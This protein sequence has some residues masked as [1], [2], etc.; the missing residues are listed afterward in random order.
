[1]NTLRQLLAVTLLLPVLAIAQPTPAEAAAPAPA[2]PA[3]AMA[4][5]PEGTPATS[6]APAEAAT[7]NFGAGLSFAGVGTAYLAYQGGSSQTAWYPSAFAPT[8]SLERRLALRTWLAFGF[9]AAVGRQSYEPTSAGSSGSLDGDSQLLVLRA[10]VRQVVWSRSRFE[11]SVFALGEVGTISL[12]SKYQQASGDLTEEK[13]SSWLVGASAEVSVDREL[14]PGLSVR[15]ATPL[16]HAAWQSGEWTSIGATTVT[17]KGHDL[18]V[19]AVLSPRLE[20]RFA[21]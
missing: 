17:N 12:S 8:A 11:V 19:T 4:L 10:G 6:A 1:M 20:L 7:W 16:L 21:F 15:L 18:Q 13:W 5:A 9:N 3:P 2:A 14:I